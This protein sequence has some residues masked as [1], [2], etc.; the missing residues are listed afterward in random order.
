MALPWQHLVRENAIAFSKN[1]SPLIFYHSSTRANRLHRV[2]AIRPPFKDN[3]LTDTYRQTIYQQYTVYVNIFSYRISNRNWRAITE[4]YGIWKCLSLQIFNL[5]TKRFNDNFL[6]PN[7]AVGDC[8]W[9]AIWYA[10]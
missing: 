8:E 4:S 1:C 5:K 3:A 7:Y 9:N 10:S 6:F 2:C